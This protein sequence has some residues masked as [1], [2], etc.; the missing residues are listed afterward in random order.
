MKNRPTKCSKQLNYNYS[1]VMF[2][3]RKK[4]VKVADVRGIICCIYT[5][6]GN[7]ILWWWLE[8][9]HILKGS[10]CIICL[11]VLWTKR[12]RRWKFMLKLNYF[13]AYECTSRERS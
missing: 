8:Y 9:K 13:E 7:C 12:A 4:A 2:Y 10:L 6:Y 3:D 5:M 1:F 11:F